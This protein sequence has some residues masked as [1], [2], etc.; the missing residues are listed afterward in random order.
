MNRKQSYR[1]WTALLT[2]LALILLFGSSLK[3][4][5][6]YFTTYTTTRG[7]ARLALGP[8]S[9]IEETIERQT[10]QIQIENTGETDC[11]VR[12]RIYAGSLLQLTEREVV[13]E[14]GGSHWRKD[15]DGWWY[16]EAILKPGEKTNVLSVKIDVTREMMDQKIDNFNVVVVQESTLVLYREDGTPYADWELSI[17]SEERGGAGS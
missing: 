11:F 15:G 7:S 2:A 16:Y 12:A 8:R 17:K 14:G 13:P 5:L 9:E 3:D 1:K 10:K 4:S 6:A